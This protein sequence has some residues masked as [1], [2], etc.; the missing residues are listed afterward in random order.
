MTFY[1]N[2]SISSIY[3]AHMV[4]SFV[5][6]FVRSFV[7]SDVCTSSRSPSLPPLPVN[8]FLPTLHPSRVPSRPVMVGF[9]LVFN[10]EI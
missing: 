8:P 4:H 5:R 6:S 10:I 9:T 3:H 1:H 7:C 2:F